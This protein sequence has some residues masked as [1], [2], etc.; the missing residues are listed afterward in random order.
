MIFSSNYHIPRNVPRKRHGILENPRKMAENGHFSRIFPR[1]CL[2]CFLGRRNT[3]IYPREVGSFSRKY[4]EF[5][6]I[7]RNIS[8]NQPI[9]DPIPRK[10]WLVFLEK[11]LEI[12]GPIS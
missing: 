2:L 11:I 6:G 1:K 12:C 3:N 7:P 5:L 9:F 10:T 4:R 8:R